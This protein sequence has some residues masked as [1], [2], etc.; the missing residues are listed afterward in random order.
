MRI[1]QVLDLYD[2][3]K[4][5]VA[6]ATERNVRMLKS[7]GHSVLVVSTGNEMEGKVTVDEFKIPFF[8]YLVDQQ[9]FTFAKADQAVR[10]FAA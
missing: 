7:M 3:P 1:V 4:N 10:R 2:E 8:Q 9:G 5:G 6:T